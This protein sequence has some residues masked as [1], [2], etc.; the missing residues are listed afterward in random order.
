MSGG[1]VPEAFRHPHF[2][3]K[4]AVHVANHL[5]CTFDKSILVLTTRRSSSNTNFILFKC[6]CIG[7]KFL[8]SGFE[9]L[10]RDTFEGICPAV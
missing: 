9:I 6:A 5:S 10:I 1:P 8:K 3:E 4:G 2:C 7:L